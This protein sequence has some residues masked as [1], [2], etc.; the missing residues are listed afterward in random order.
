[1]PQL[2]LVSSNHFL[3]CLRFCWHPPLYFP[4]SL[5]SGLCYISKWRL[6]FWKARL[7]REKSVLS[8][9]YGKTRGKWS[10]YNHSRGQSFWSWPCAF[11]N[12]RFSS[13]HHRQG[14]CSYILL[15]GEAGEKSRAEKETKMHKMVTSCSKCFMQSSA[16]APNRSQFWAR[17]KGNTYI[18]NPPV[19]LHG[20]SNLRKWFD[21]VLCNK[22]ST[23]L[24]LIQQWES[25][26]KWSDLSLY[27]QNV[28][29]WDL[30]YYFHL[31]YI[32]VRPQVYKLRVIRIKNT[33]FILLPLFP[34]HSNF[35]MGT[36]K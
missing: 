14:V 24:P 23:V 17:S 8:K 1:M 30:I 32:F 9:N 27:I 22:R 15:W 31:N 12:F 36:P 28:I 4:C 6:H 11:T 35:S 21:W 20:F 5:F 10:R 25:P 2:T 29:K 34:L 16:T 26:G 18:I 7:A 13:E 3:W 19:T 33:Q